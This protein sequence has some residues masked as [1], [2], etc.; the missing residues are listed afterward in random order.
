MR[1]G[2]QPKYSDMLPAE[3]I[4]CDGR[5]MS[6]SR[7]AKELEISPRLLRKAIHDGD[8]RACRLGARTVRVSF[9]DVRRW[10]AKK[11]VPVN[12]QARERA[13]E[14]LEA[15]RLAFNHESGSEK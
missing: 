4:A 6:V 15:E 10:V 11:R 8:L 9:L 12:R 1:G 3:R 14:I 2:H 5:L 7:I 13:I